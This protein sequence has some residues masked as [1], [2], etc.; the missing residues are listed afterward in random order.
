MHAC[1]PTYIVI[2]YVTLNYV[3]YITYTNYLCQKNMNE[4]KLQADT[5]ADA[6]VDAGSPGHGARGA[7]ARVERWDSHGFTNQPIFYEISCDLL[8]FHEILN[9]IS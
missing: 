3:T 2:S 9:V 6:G 1:M 4:A 7:R 8:G 5:E